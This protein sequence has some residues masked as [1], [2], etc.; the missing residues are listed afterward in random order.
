MI[1]LCLLCGE[2]CKTGTIHTGG[3]PPKK[4]NVYDAHLL[5]LLRYPPG[6]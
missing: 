3:L 1:H 2:G 6:W 5:E 4:E